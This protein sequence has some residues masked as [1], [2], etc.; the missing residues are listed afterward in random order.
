MKI[1]NYSMKNRFTLVISLLSATLFAQVS[2]SGLVGYW[3][4]NGN[5]NDASGNNLNGI[6]YG[7]TLTADRFGNPNSAYSFNGSSNY[8]EIANNAVLELTTYTEALW[9]YAPVSNGANLEQLLVKGPPPY[10]YTL[11]LNSNLLPASGFNSGNSEVSLLAN[12]STTSGKWHLLAFTNDGSTAIIYLDNV[13][14]ATKSVTT[15]VPTTGN[16][17]VATYDGTQEFFG[18]SIDEIRLY[19]RALSAGE[20]GAMYVETSCSAPLP[21]ASNQSVCGS[22]SVT[23]NAT[24]GSTYYWYSNTNSQVATGAS[25]TTPNLT[26]STTYYVANNNGTCTSALVAVNATVNPLPSISFS[27][28]PSSILYESNAVQLSVTPV[29]GTFSGPGVSGS[30]FVPGSAGLGKKVVTY[31]YTDVNSCTNKASLA[32]IVSDTIACKQSSA[33]TLVIDAQ[34]TGI[35]GPNNTNIIKMYPNPTSQDLFINFG[36][37]TSMNGYTVKIANLLGQVVYSGLVS[38][39]QITINLS[40]WTGHG[41]YIVTILDPS[42][43]V[44][45]TRVILVQ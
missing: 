3:P 21:I 22:G 39:Q 26:S 42:S 32:T 35:S 20:I 12:T 4:F 45:D 40:T 30:S 23:F 38:Q 7:A 2:T 1:K 31:T 11:D 29:G 41:N 43:K 13:V 37:Y 36:N 33:D 17:F 8:I 24:G 16:I 19:N 25:Y 34:L 10:N 27:S 28:L 15:T 9:F 18:G 14:V 44:I 5:A 6:V